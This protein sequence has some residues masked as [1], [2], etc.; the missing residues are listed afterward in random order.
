[1]A[2]IVKAV[3]TKVNLNSKKGRQLALENKIN[4]I[5][6]RL[7]ELGVSELKFSVTGAISN[8]ETTQNTV[9]IDTCTDINWLF[10]TLAYFKNIQNEH[11]RFCKDANITTKL[12]ANGQ[13]YLV[14]DILRDLELR[15]VYLS[16]AN[17]INR[18]TQ[19]KSELTPFMNEESRFIS[20]LK[21]VD[22]LLKS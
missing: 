16:N 22:S 3:N 9:R 5:D 2:N 8:P 21:R 17:E 4:E 14:Q 19:I 7:K 18:L 10:R 13:G 6:E 20:A 12:I 11:K 1:M 15:I